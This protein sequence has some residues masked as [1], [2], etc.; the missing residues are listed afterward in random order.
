MAGLLSEKKTERNRKKEDS[1]LIVSGGPLDL[2]F[3]AAFFGERSYDFVIAV[4]GGLTSA[5]RLGIYPNLLVGDFDTYGREKILEYQR[6]S[7]LPMEIHKPEKDETDTELAFRSAIKYG[8]RHADVIG[9]TG[10]RID[11]EISNI[12]LLLQAKRQGL[13]ASLYDKKNRVYLLDA[14]VEQ[15]KIFHRNEIYGK[16]ISFLPLSEEVKGITLRGFK[17]PLTKKDI[18]ILENPSL[19]VSNEMSGERAEMTFDQGIL[20]CVESHD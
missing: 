20:I 5:I 9:A 2:E 16:Y 19:C 14:S 18:S 12:H 3:G 13:L 17:Y 7:G 11:H 8:F 10:G 1:C 15:G 4:D 6:N